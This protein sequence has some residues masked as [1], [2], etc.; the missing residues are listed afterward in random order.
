MP[1]HFPF[2]YR[3]AL[4]LGLMLVVSLVDYHRNGARAVKFREYGFVI[5][6]GV[7][8]AMVGF[9]N[10]LITSSISPDYFILGKGL[11]E[12]PDLQVQ[13]GLFGLQVGFSAG[14]IGGAVCLYASRRKSAHPPA[15]FSSLFRLLWMPVAG[16]ILGGIALPLGFSKFDPV[17]FSAQ[18]EPLLS[19]GRIS[20]FRQV[21]WT[22]IGL[23]AGMVVGLAAMILCAAKE[24]KNPARKPSC[25][26]AV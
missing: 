13:S 8:G 25:S 19:A 24:R 20:R 21:W 12:S 1:D 26:P 15:K 11:E 4:L 17:R 14:V 2:S 9:V 7:V 22:H 23:Y 10:D 18:L 5:I 6:A 16:A 3:I